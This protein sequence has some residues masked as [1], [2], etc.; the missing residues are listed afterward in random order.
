[1]SETSVHYTKAP[2]S[3]KSCKTYH[4]WKKLINVWSGLTSL[5]KEKQASA[6]LLSLEGEAQDAALEIEQDK[7]SAATG[8]D[9][10]IARLDILYIKD[11]IAEQ[12]NALE[13]LETWKKES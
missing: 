7:L 9:E 5:A 8:L 6:V 11:E 3:I 12:Y 13:N 2:P 4:D 10:I 1:M